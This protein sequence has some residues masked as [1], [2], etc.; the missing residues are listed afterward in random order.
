MISR[1]KCESQK[2]SLVA[3]K[4]TIISCNPKAEKSEYQAQDLITRA[5]ELQKWLHSRPQR[6]CYA[7]VKVLAQR[8]PRL[9]DGSTRPSGQSRCLHSSQVLSPVIFLRPNIRFR[10]GF[11]GSPMPD[12]AEGHV[13]EECSDPCQREG[14]KNRS[15]GLDNFFSFFI[16]WSLHLVFSVP[17]TFCF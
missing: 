1:V 7:K 13:S 14:R 15:L 12:R 10:A 17:K 9:Q 2:T 4:E 11:P 16:S 8:V 6:I 3:H 5:A